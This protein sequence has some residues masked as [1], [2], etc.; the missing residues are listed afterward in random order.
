MH[1][2]PGI[3]SLK[4]LTS[5][6]AALFRGGAAAPLW[7]PSSPGVVAPPFSGDSEVAILHLDA[8]HSAA[9]RL[10]G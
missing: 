10:S 7:A 1:V 3:S 9:N 4:H 6:S 2:C 8:S 5:K